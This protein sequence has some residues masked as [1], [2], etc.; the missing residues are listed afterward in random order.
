[1]AG[2]IVSDPNIIYEDLAITKPLPI[3]KIPSPFTPTYLGPR[4]GGARINTHA[5]YLENFNPPV[6][7][8]DPTT[9]KKSYVQTFNGI[10]ET[11]PEVPILYRYEAEVMN[12]NNGKT[13]GGFDRYNIN[14][15][16]SCSQ[17]LSGH[18]NFM[19]FAYNPG[20]RVF[21]YDKLYTPVIRGAH[22]S[23]D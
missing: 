15:I 23:T 4:F 16:P 1:M 17:R 12:V 14:T 2:V 8:P 18:A 3:Y 21:V 10:N 5:P 11:C 22:S 6:Y 7:Q 9:V 13:F 20:S 19:D